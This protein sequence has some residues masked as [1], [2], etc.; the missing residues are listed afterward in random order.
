MTQCLYK[1]SIYGSFLLLALFSFFLSANHAAAYALYSIQST[2]TPY[3]VGVSNVGAAQLLQTLQPRNAPSG[4]FYFTGSFSSTGATLNDWTWNGSYNGSAGGFNGNSATLGHIY[5]QDIPSAAD[6]TDGIAGHEIV[7]HDDLYMCVAAIDKGMYFSPEF[8]YLGTDGKITDLPC[9]HFKWAGWDYEAQAAGSTTPQVSSSFTFA[10]CSLANFDLG[11]CAADIVI[12]MVEP[13][14]SAIDGFTGLQTLLN[15][16][17]PVGYFA[18]IHDNLTATTT[19]TPAF[20]ITIPPD[21]KSTVFNPFDI[22][23][24]GLLGIFYMLSFYKRLKNINI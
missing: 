20:T 17:P 14:Q 24:A 19:A 8:W 11:L 6:A 3:I 18:M 9:L 22:A 23:V 12:G 1:K 16:K 15:Q 10:E 21:L 5:T 4:S 7:G 2:S 13:D